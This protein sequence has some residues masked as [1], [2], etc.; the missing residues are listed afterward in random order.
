LAEKEEE[1]QDD[2]EKILEKARLFF[3]K[4]AERES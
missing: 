3:E 4:E 1:D 2:E